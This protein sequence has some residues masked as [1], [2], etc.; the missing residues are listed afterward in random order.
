MNTNASGRMDRAPEGAQERSLTF[1][2][3]RGGSF[4]EEVDLGLPV[5]VF[6]QSLVGRYLRDAH[7]ERLATG[8]V[9]AEEGF[10]VDRTLLGHLFVR[11]R[12]P[13]AGAFFYDDRFTVRSPT[14][15]SVRWSSGDSISE[16]SVG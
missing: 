7:G 11:P 5:P 6:V 1:D 3:H 2:R 13:L 16:S 9:C 8:E 14:Y 4:E 10:P 15:I 12:V